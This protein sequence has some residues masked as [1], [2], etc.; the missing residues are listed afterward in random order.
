[1]KTYT[2]K[3]KTPTVIFLVEN[4]IA[5]NPAEAVEM[6]YK[7]THAFIEKADIEINFITDETEEE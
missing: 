2:V 1:M 4:I 6:A 7:R 3:L 5:E